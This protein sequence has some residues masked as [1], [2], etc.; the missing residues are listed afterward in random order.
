VPTNKRRS[1]VSWETFLTLLSGAI[2]LGS[3][4]AKDHLLEGTSE[5]LHVLQSAKSN[6]KLLK[7]IQTGQEQT[8]RIMDRLE[9][10]TSS[11][12]ADNVGDVRTVLQAAEQLRCLNLASQN[13]ESNL[14]NLDELNKI[15]VLS[16]AQST[17]L[18]ELKKQFN[19]GNQEAASLA[20]N[21]TGVPSNGR[22]ASPNL[23]A[24]EIELVTSGT[25]TLG[26]AQFNLVDLL[27]RAESSLDQEI[28]NTERNSRHI[29]LFIDLLFGFGWLLTVG[30]KMTR[31]EAVIEAI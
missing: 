26:D 12:C 13:L 10:K 27:H 18:E 25:K 3:F 15:H 6:L 22:P 19:H 20:L 9:S 28:E 29:T 16:S 17:E 1:K 11:H 4:V 30:A 21:L 5:R 24:L 23:D 8:L 31:T 14:Y 2:I 7:G